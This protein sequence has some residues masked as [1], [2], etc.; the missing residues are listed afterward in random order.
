MQCER[1]LKLFDFR[2]GFWNDQ[3][4]L[5]AV[6]VKSE[7]LVVLALADGVVFMRV[8]TSASDCQSKPNGTRCFGTIKAGLDSKLLLIGSTLSVG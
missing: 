5:I 6:V 7:Q 8:A 2:V 4:L 1:L 3:V